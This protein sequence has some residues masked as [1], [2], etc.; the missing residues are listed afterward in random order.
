[1]SR[2]TGV[3]IAAAGSGSRFGRR[4]QF[5]SLGGRPILHC[6]L[7]AFAAVRDVAELIVVCPAVALDRAQRIVDRW[8]EGDPRR[9]VEGPTIR[10]IAGGPR[11]QDSVF[12]GLEA[13]QASRYVLVHDAARPLV[14]PGDVESLLD[15]VRETGAAAIGTPCSDSLKH[16]EDGL[17]QGEVDR[18]RIWAVQTPQGAEI[19]RLRRAYAAVGARAEWTDEASLLRAAGVAVTPVEGW[20]GNMKVTTPGDQLLAEGILRALSSESSV[21]GGAEPE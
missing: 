19:E 3:V 12:L 21:A 4:K 20:R 8:R 9:R 5:L 17:I 1:M 6:S 2:D 18:T 11:R 7:D 14:R 15:A 16:V 13:L 10:V